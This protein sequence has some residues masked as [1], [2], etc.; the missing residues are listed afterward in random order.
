MLNYS[1][2]IK[3]SEKSIRSWRV[4]SEN[5]K[6]N[7]KES[8]TIFVIKQAS[9]YVRWAKSCHNGTKRSEKWR[10]SIKLSTKP[11]KSSWATSSWFRRPWKRTASGTIC[12][13]FLTSKWEMKRRRRLYK[14]RR[15]RVRKHFS[16][17]SKTVSGL[18]RKGKQRQLS[19]RLSKR[20]L[21]ICLQNSKA[22]VR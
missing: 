16:K 22:R 4:I 7:R 20:S 15:K 1:S 17:L 18:H 5:W 10:R 9:L 13:P 8:A 21:A 2:Q 11:S 12:R 3:P 19:S 14:K 6:Q